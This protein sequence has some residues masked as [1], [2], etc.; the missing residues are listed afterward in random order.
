[1]I[2]QE[3]LRAQ[4]KFASLHGFPR[5]TIIC[6]GRG[7]GKRLLSAYIAELLQAQMVWCSPKVEDVRNVIQLAYQQSQ[8]TL[9]VLPDADKMSLA[10]KNA[11]LKITEDSPRKSYFVMTL[12]DSEN[13]LPT[14]LS[15]AFVCN[16]NPYSPQE[17]IEYAQKSGYQLTPQ[18]IEVVS[19]ICSLPGDVDLA[20]RYSILDF[21]AYVEKVVDNILEVSG[22]NA[23]KIGSKLYYKE[24]DSGWDITLFFRT[25]MLVLGNRMKEKPSMM[26]VKQIVVT[27]HYANQMNIT[28]INKASTVDMWVLAMRE[29]ER[30]YDEIL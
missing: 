2:G 15:R 17:I 27:G 18:E 12:Q 7:G 20:V 26:Y 1:M 29:P 13:T 25:V 16:L 9:Y 19:N 14:L 5:F 24:G 28:G 6:G 4:L 21:Y 11:L 30:I 3:K 23:M 8:P 22:V 10:A